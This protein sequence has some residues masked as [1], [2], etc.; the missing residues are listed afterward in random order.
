MAVEYE[1]YIFE[2]DNTPIGLLP[3][4]ES[5]TYLLATNAIGS[6]LIQIGDQYSGDIGED[7]RLEIYRNG[8]LVGGTQFLIVRDSPELDQNGQYTTEIKAVSALGVLDWPI[9]NYAPGL[10]QS[11]HSDYAGNIIKQLVRENIGSEADDAARDMS[12]NLDVQAD[13]DDGA[14]VTVDVGWARL[15]SAIQDVAAAS[16]EEGT[17]LFF[18]IIKNGSGKLELQTFSGQ[19]GNDLSGSVV[20]SPERGSLITA[21][22]DRSYEKAASRAIVAGT[23]QELWRNVAEVANTDQTNNSPWG[24]IKEK[25]VTTSQATTTT[26]AIQFGEIYLAQNRNKLTLSGK[27]MPTGGAVYGT[28]Y[29]FGD[30]VT[31]EF[32]GNVAVVSIDRVQVSVKDG[33][34]TIDI[35]LRGDVV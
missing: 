21:R 8:T 2:P 10:L 6:A 7:Y 32:L 17:E 28:D 19:R 4:F 23:G 25:L 15:W 5:L 24:Y 18:D 33:A 35:T 20:L 16:K 3:R 11:H 26:E 1:I 9:V 14:V 13:A 34:E 31:M 29:N 30:L 12:T 27:P 22:L